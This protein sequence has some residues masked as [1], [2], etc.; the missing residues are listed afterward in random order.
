[1]QKLNV[2]STTAPIGATSLHELKMELERAMRARPGDA[3]LR[4]D[5]AACLRVITHPL[6]MDSNL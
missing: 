6:A 5:Y 2:I 1:M 4:A 3:A